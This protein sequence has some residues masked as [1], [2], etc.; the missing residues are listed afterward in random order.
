M[1]EPHVARRFRVGIVVL[2]ALIA[3]MS[4]IFMVGR[5]ANLFKKKFPY[6]TRFD[7]ASGLVTGNPVRLN[8]VTVGNVIEVVLSPDPADRTVRVVYD[9]DRRAAPRLRK[10][11]RASIKTIGLLGDKYVDLEGGTAEESEVPIGGVIPAAP[12]AG[13]EKLLEG[14]GDLVGDLAAI[15][16]SLKN[17][18]GRTE[19]GK[20]FLGA[21]TS[22]S[23]ESDKLGNDLHATLGNLNVILKKINSGQGLVGRLLIDEKYGKETADS[24]REAVRSVQGV[25][26]KIDEQMRTNTGAIPALLADP[27]GKKKVYGLL[28]NLSTAAVSLAGVTNQLEKGN[29][30]LPLL[31]RDERFG[32]E[33][34]R[35]LQNFSRRL[36][37]IGKKLDEGSGTAGKLINDPA[38]FDAAHDLVVGV[39]ESKLLRWLIRD[40]QKSGIRKRY[41]QAQ[42]QANAAPA[43][44]DG[45]EDVPTPA[46]ASTPTPTPVPRT[47][48][49]R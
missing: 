45:D 24:L 47:R 33:L 28:D 25:F 6:E 3:V 40:R 36:D 5:R 27:E 11:T 10:G 29:G 13:I 41:A 9:V 8:G 17:I 32:K 43:D 12:G 19:Q 46:P 23:Q 39:N 7:S 18:L 44:G 15:A 48:A 42:A 34:T 20:G 37:S 2:F 35:N 4:G 30:A 1:V 14:S 21:L 31:I 49:P 38:I 26:G 22:D 16:R